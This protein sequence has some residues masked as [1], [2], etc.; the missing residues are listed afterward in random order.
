MRRAPFILAAL[1]ASGC[2]DVAPDGKIAAGNQAEMVKAA[3][4][5]APRPSTAP[6]SDCAPLPTLALS[7]EFG[8]SARLF[9][10]DSSPFRQTKTAFEA[11]YRQACASGILGKTPLIAPDV[12][13][14]GALLLKNAPDANIASIYREE[15]GDRP[16]VLEYP[17]VT[18]DGGVQV[19]TS[20]ELGEAIYCS[21]RGGSDQEQEESGRCLPD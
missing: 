10:P 12:A 16:M 4:A 8:E 11:A 5:P 21:V 15:G 9:S 7:D 19:P 1:L 18:R 20:E 14:P 13:R 6:S 2:G 17:F 3:P